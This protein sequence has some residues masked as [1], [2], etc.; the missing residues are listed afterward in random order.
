MDS[1]GRKCC[2]IYFIY[3]VFCR[4]VRARLT[5]Q[6]NGCDIT[7]LYYFGS[8][9]DATQR[10]SRCITQHPLFQTI[11][12][13]SEVLEIAIVGLCQ[14]RGMRAPRELNNMKAYVY[15]WSQIVYQL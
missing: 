8:D 2:L 13:Q 3:F 12:F 5:W 9:K 7:C 4:G 11:C 1:V 6:R 15:K 10:T 14:V